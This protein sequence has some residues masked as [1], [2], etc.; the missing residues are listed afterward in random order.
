M[1]DLVEDLV[2][3][4]GAALLRMAWALTGDPELAHDLVQDALVK[5]VVHRRRVEAADHPR[6]YLRKILLNTH[7]DRRHRPTL[8]EDEKV[9]PDPAEDVVER[10]VLVAAMTQLSPQQRQ[11][12]ALRF[13]DDQ[14]VAQTAALLGCSQQTVKTQTS[15]AVAT[16]RAH[17]QLQDYLPDEGEP[18]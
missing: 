14:S 9:S 2:R 13:F 12:V 6:A 17:P 15:R 18:S 4:E 3:A 7:R 10:A 11:V 16:L 5:V 8:G 1:A